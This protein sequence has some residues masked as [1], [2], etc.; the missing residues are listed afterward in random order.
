MQKNKRK[1]KRQTISQM[2]GTRGTIIA[3]PTVADVV[4]KKKNDRKDVKRK[5]KRGDY[6][7]F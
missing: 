5:L 1:K 2:T 3:P 6:D 7:G 4:K